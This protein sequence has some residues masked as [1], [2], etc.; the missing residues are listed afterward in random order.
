[1][2]CCFL[3][4]AAKFNGS[5]AHLSASDLGSHCI[6][7]AVRRANDSSLFT[8]ID[9]VIMGQVYTCGVGQ[10]PARQAVVRAA[11][12]YTV[13]ATTVNMVCGSGMRAVANAYQ[14][15][16]S[17]DSTLVLAGGQESMTQVSRSLK[18]H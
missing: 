7:E 12:P 13:N 3:L 16:R 14:A 10:N 17:G 18:H 8:D 4:C 1:M 11:L 15:I 5:Y 9:E 2:T 6:R